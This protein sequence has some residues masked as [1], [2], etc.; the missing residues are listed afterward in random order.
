MILSS[1]IVVYPAESL[2]RSGLIELKKT[3]G[4]KSVPNNI[5]V[6]PQGYLGFKTNENKEWSLRKHLNFDSGDIL[7]VGAGHVQPRKGVDWFFETCKYLKDELIK[8]ADDRASKLKFVWLGNGYNVDDTN[9]S[10]WLDAYISRVGIADAC[11]FPGAVDNVTEALKDADIFL[12]TSRLDPFPNVAIDALNVDCSIGLFEEASGIVDFVRKYSARAAIGEYGDSRD[13]ANKIYSDF[14]ALLFK[15]GKNSEICKIK[16]NFENYVENISEYLEEAVTIRE[17]IAQASLL[18]ELNDNFDAEFYS[19]TLL[20]ID[21]KKNHFLSL[22]AKGVVVSK[23]FPGVD[24][25]NIMNFLDV[26]KIDLNSAI[27]SIFNAIINDMP[28][29][30]V[31]GVVPDRTY[32]GRIALQFHVYFN[33]LIPE[34]CAYFKTLINHSVDLYVTHVFDLEEKYKNAMIHAING[35]VYFI[36]VKNIGR[37]VYPFHK[38]FCDH[39][40]GNYDVVGHIHTKKSKDVQEGIGDRWRRYLLANLMGSREASAEILGLFSDPK[41]GLVFSEDSHIVDEGANG[42]FIEEI[43]DSVGQSR[44]QDY[45]NFPLGTMFWARTEALKDLNKLDKEIFALPEP[46]PY[47]GSVLHAFERVIPQLVS[48]AGYEV[49]RVYTTNTNW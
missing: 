12:L 8:N 2:K 43:L 18:P 49:K 44:T 30:K 39:I 14:D 32:D 42:N 38:I 19:N 34:Y 21:Q 47:D 7:I 3:T 36:K 20:S 15:D 31:L 25:S 4:I 17:H 13:L 45:I 5:R 22:L 9:V 6:Q 41:I 10:V 29:H 24:I 23:P 40:Y 16:L 33:D 46:I 37:D 27:K 1:D 11:F 28:V 48:I 35:D 26:D